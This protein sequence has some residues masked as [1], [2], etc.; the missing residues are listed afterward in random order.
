MTM[1]LGSKHCKQE[2]T[3]SACRENTAVRQMW[4]SGHH[5]VTPCRTRAGPRIQGVGCGARLHTQEIGAHE[6]CLSHTWAPDLSLPD[7]AFLRMPLSTGA[8]RLSVTVSTFSS[9]QLSLLFLLLLLQNATPYP[10]PSCC[11]ILPWHTLLSATALPDMVTPFC[12]L[13]KLYFTCVM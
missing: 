5:L 9:E 8:F 12:A 1:H 7:H 2:V 4:N 13:R 3:L 10:N 6:L 11:F